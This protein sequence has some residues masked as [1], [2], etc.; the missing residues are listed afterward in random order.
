VSPGPVSFPVKVLGTG[1]ALLSLFLLIG[2]LLP[3]DWEAT[4]THTIAA[5]AEDVMPFLDSPEGWRQWTP[6][7]EEGV[8]R[9]GPSRGPGARL[10]WN[11]PELGSGSF[12]IVSAEPERV[13]YAVEVDEG[14]MVSNGVIALTPANGGVRVDWHEQGDLGRNPLMGYWA[15][16][17]GRAQSEELTKGL[18]RLDS[19][20][21][22]PRP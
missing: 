2:L 11:D 20:V 12:T 22:R 9:S 14:T 17:M 7:P 16:S 8:D 15:L 13:E 19:L 3:G 4:A 10:S 18:E 21:V 1:A 5:P 6:W